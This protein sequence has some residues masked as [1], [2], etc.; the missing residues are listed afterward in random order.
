MKGL[1]AEER[2]TLRKEKAVA[3]LT[4]LKAWMLENYKAVLPKSTICK[5]P[6][7]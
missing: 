1:P 2:L 4:D 7:K 3:I 6:R 5:L